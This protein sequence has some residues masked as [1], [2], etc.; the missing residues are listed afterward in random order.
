MSADTLTRQV[1]AKARRGCLGCLWQV[2][3]VLLLGVVL[4]IALTGVFYPWAF[5]LGGKFHILPYWQGVGRAHAESGDYLVWVQ[6]E[7]TT[8]GSRLYMASNLTGNAYV[9]TPKAERFRMHLGG[10]MRKNLNLST[11]GE[12]IS[13]YMN[14]W[15]LFYGQFIGDRRPRL[16]FRGK[17][18]NPNIVMDDHGSIGRAFEPDGTVYRG[19]GGSRPYMDEVVPITFVQGS[20]SEFDKACAALRR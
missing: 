3:L 8:R 4:M 16:E 14:Y 6:F 5:Y 18:Q 20:R 10:S 12:A 15:P 7:P 19:H 1:G 11:D 13:L 17:W 2:G 9:C